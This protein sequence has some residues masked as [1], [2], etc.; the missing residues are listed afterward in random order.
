MVVVVTQV[1][2]DEMLAAGRLAVQRLDAAKFPFSGALWLL[3]EDARTWKFVVVVSKSGAHV[4]PKVL[5]QRLRRILTQGGRANPPIALSD[6][7]V[8]SKADPLIRTLSLVLKTSGSDAGIRM[9]GNTINGY[10][11]EDAYIY[12]LR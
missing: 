2:T 4:G 9:T 1:L 11:I 6:I 10:Y 8:V 5:Y 3:D 12:R 7:F